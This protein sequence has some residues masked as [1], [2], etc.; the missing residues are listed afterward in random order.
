[1]SEAKRY[2]VTMTV[3]Y[4]VEVSVLAESANDAHINA[5]HDFV[6]PVPTTAEGVPF[7]LSG[8]GVIDIEREDG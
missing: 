2:R 6:P 4:T 7:L 8:I 3:R 5:T 1:M